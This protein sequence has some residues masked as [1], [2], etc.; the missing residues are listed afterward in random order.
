VLAA[1]LRNFTH[2]S[3]DVDREGDTDVTQ[4][5]EGGNTDL[6]HEGCTSSNTS[7]L[8]PA[9]GEGEGER[10]SPTHGMW[11]V[12]LA[13]G[14]PW[15]IRSPVNYSGSVILHFTD[16]KESGTIHAVAHTGQEYYDEDEAGVRHR[17]ETKNQKD[18][19]DT[20]TK[21]LKR[22]SRRKT[23][24]GILIFFMLA[25]ILIFTRLTPGIC[26]PWSLST[27]RYVCRFLAVIFS[28]CECVR[29]LFTRNWYGFFGSRSTPQKSA[30]RDDDEES[31]DRN[32]LTLNTRHNSITTL[33]SITSHVN[34]S[35]NDR[36]NVWKS[37]ST[38]GNPSREDR[39]D[40]IDGGERSRKGDLIVTEVYDR[41]YQND[42]DEDSAE[43]IQKSI[44]FVSISSNA[45]SGSSP[46]K[47]YITWGT[48]THLSAPIFTRLVNESSSV[49]SRSTNSSDGGYGSVNSLSSVDS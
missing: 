25:V 38:S 22:H 39:L 17:T 48:S 40:R 30:E 20:I 42:S 10:E 7:H 34:L 2:L 26:S 41:I 44:S 46:R 11:S 49:Q 33:N 45:S 9:A 47:K 8:V 18:A 24:A 16:T 21:I 43:S 12:E 28:R 15:T 19:E 3:V 5:G 36:N 29:T 4:T 27:R 31:T 35:F 14:Y 6:G 13:M 1:G 37:R 32:L 23:V